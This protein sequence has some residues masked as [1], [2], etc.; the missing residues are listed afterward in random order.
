MHSL[1]SHTLYSMNITHPSTLL[2]HYSTCYDMC[3]QRSPYNWSRELYQRHGETIE[4]YLLLRLKQTDS[5]FA[6]SPFNVGLIGEMIKSKN[7]PARKHADEDFW[8]VITADSSEIRKLF[9][10]KPLDQLFKYVDKR[11]SLQLEKISR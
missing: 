6:V 5:G 2:L 7:L 4:N 10:S 8:V 3:T 9:N 11:Q 1:F